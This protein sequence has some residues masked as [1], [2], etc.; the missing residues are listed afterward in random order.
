MRFIYLYTFLAEL[1]K[2]YGSQ[3]WNTL[4]EKEKRRKNGNEKAQ[5]VLLTSIS[6][7]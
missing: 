2:Y 5:V 6:K 4:T 1:N 3:K 7:Y